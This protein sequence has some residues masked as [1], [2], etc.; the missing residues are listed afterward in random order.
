MDAPFGEIRVGL[1][2]IFLK[3]ELQPT[4]EPRS[5]FSALAMLVSLVL[6]A[7]LSNIALQPLEAIGRRLGRHDGRGGASQS[8]KPRA[9]PTN[10]AG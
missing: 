6:A 5:G 3:N 7:G 8:R 9:R 10:T 2:T 1:S 4:T